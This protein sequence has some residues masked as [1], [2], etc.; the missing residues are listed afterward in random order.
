MKANVYTDKNPRCPTTEE[1]ADF[2]LTGREQSIP[3]E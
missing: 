1:D 2:K 3:M